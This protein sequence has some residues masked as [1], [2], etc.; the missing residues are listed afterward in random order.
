M[1]YGYDV[2]KAKAHAGDT[3]VEFYRQGL[4]RSKKFRQDYVSR[5]RVVKAADMPF[6]RSPDGL[7]KHIVNEEMG[8]LNS[9]SRCT[10]SSSNLGRNQ[11]NTAIWPRRSST[12]WRDVAMTFTGT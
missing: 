10:C 6:E 2:E 4:D 11:G 12:Y 5:L 8:T 1:S 3:F 7:I 9:P